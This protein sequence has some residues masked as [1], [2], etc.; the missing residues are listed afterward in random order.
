MFCSGVIVGQTAFFNSLITEANGYNLQVSRSSYTR[1]TF[2]LRLKCWARA[3][4]STV[5]VFYGRS[6]MSTLKSNVPV[7]TNQDTSGA[8]LLHVSHC[9]L[10]CA[11][12]SIPS[13]GV[14]FW[15]TRNRLVFWKKSK[16][17]QTGLIK[18]LHDAL[19]EKKRELFFSITSFLLL[20]YE[21]LHRTILPS[22]IV[23]GLISK[24]KFFIRV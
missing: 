3:S 18:N 5:E 2:I 16:L 14:F 17:S 12:G 8:S 7:G 21:F 10:Q 13:I 20:I 15:N 4:F 1:M 6:L 9:R 22:K 23:V 19:A 11:Q 24:V